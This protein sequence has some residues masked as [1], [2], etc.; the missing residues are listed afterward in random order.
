MDI[1]KYGSGP[2]PVGRALLRIGDAWSLLILRDAGY[3]ATRFE[4][5]RASLGIAPN[6][7]T[8]R[9]TAL[10]AEKLLTKHRYSTHPPRDEYV[11]TEKGREVLPILA[12]IGAWGRRYHGEGG[13]S[14]LVNE[15]TGG[16]IEPIVVDAA[17]GKPLSDLR[18]RLV[19][20]AATNHAA[21]P[22]SP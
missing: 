11:L 21:G 22:Q 15:E 18:T 7:L 2:C 6:I 13:T 16:R 4:Q 10:V 3:G 5:F 12:A 1:E 8:R 20:P 9:L 14:F 19:R 17:T